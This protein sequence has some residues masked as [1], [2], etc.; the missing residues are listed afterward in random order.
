MNTKNVK[1][2][3][4]PIAIMAQNLHLQLHHATSC[5]SYQ[6][7]KQNCT[8]SSGCHFGAVA[9]LCFWLLIWRP[10]TIISTQTNLRVLKFKQKTLKKW[11]FHTLIDAY[12]SPI[13][14][15][16]CFWNCIYRNVLVK[17]ASEVGFT[18]LESLCNSFV[19]NST[20]PWIAA[21]VIWGFPFSKK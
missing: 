17:N 3:F 12:F 13:A 15:P 7:E 20:N 14:P 5:L 2:S 6:L 18:L 10:L 21:L 8:W 11:V 1:M 19:I 4:A 16:F 9:F